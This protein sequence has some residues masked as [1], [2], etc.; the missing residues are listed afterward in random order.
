MSTPSVFTIPPDRPF[1]DDLV[2]GLHADP[3]FGIGSGPAAMANVRIFLPTRRACRSLAEAFIRANGGRPLLL[4]RITPLGDI[5]EEELVFQP[6]ERTD[7]QGHDRAVL[8]A[9]PPAIAPLRRQLLLARLVTKH[10]DG[11]ISPDQA[12]RLAGELARLLDQVHTEGLD[13]SALTELVPEDFARHWQI[14][15]GFLAIITQYWPKILAEDG[16]ID[17]ADRRSRLLLAQAK[18]WRE[19]PPATPVI[20]AGSTGSIPATAELLAVIARL[21]CGAVILPGLDTAADTRS[22]EALE[23]SH[24]QFAMARLLERMGL[25]RGGVGG[26]PALART[27]GPSRTPRVRLINLALRPA[28]S[29]HAEAAWPPLKQALEGVSRLVAPTPQEEARAIALVLREALEHPRRRA[30]LVTPDR[31]IARRVAGELQRWGVAVDDSAGVPLAKTP[32]GAFLR[33]TARMLI[34]A[35]APV[36]LLA[37][38]KHPLAACG[39][40][41]HALRWRVRRLERRVLRGPRPAPGLAGLRAA[42]QHSG[43]DA[44]LRDTVD[45][46]E[47]A[48]SPFTELPQTGRQPLSALFSAHLAVAEALAASKGEPGAR[49]LWLGEAGEQALAFASEVAEAADDAPALALRAYPALLD[50]L[51]SGR[52]VRPRYGRHPRLSILGP[53]EARLLAADVVVLAGL[54]E[55]T[56]PARADA[57]PWM[58]RPMMTAFGLPEPERRIG[59]AAHDFAQGFCAPEVYLSRAARVERTPTVPSRWLVRLENVVAASEMTEWL[60]DA[61]PH[62]HWQGLLDRPTEVAPVAAPSPCPPVE[63]RP[64]ALSVTRIET[65]MRDP[66]S[67]YAR[68]VLG[69]RRLDPLDADP[70]AADYGQFVHHALEA[71]IAAYPQVLPADAEERLLALGRERLGLYEDRPSVLAFWWPRFQRIVRWMIDTERERRGVV[72]AMAAEVKGE[73]CFEAPAGRFTLSARADR[74]DTLRDGGL[75]IIDYKTGMVPKKKEVEAGFAPQLPLEAAIAVRG[76][77]AGVPPRAVA[78]LEHWRLHG[79]IEGGERCPVKTA[80]VGAL[81]EEAFAGVAALVARFDFPGTPYPSRPRSSHAP[82]FSEYEHLAR[83]REWSAGADPAT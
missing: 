70:S 17:P 34:E 45:R 35:L 31:A 43:D 41:P 68:Y 9:V 75:V 19:R 76:G 3:R 24:P 71:F 21:P 54:N 16:A 39:L 5:D 42:V 46:L 7:E 18:L 6:G 33:L 30:M 12:V 26:W 81:A 47:A 66:Y 69:L 36:P 4:P 14:T 23:P 57:S 80:D 79:K 59:L 77:F 64:R 62:L 83:V 1:L 53:L 44:L 48:I 11:A 29:A 15:L 67:I 22:W 32:P 65:W 74:I 56:W 25:G 37:A 73:I 28:A 55:G 27:S 60:A 63:A 13:F 49:R 78:A 2:L 58:S 50:E 51:L 10:R 40:A 82:K 72:A 61:S 8:A 20:A 38:L 52:T